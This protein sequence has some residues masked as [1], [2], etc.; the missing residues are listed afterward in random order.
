MT[1]IKAAKTPATFIV[2]P[3]Y[4]KIRTTFHMLVFGFVSSNGMKTAKIA[5][6][7]DIY[8]SVSI[9]RTSSQTYHY[10]ADLAQLIGVP[11]IG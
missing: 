1:K 9:A 7:S 8:L 11:P 4:E 3:K 5:A 6:K 10:C 2:I